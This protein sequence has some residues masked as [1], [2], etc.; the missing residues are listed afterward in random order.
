MANDSR[1]VAVG[2]PRPNGAVCHAPIGTALPTDETTPLDPAFIDLGYVHADGLERAIT[3][4]FEDLKAWG[5]DTVK[6]PQTEVGVSFTFT[7][8]ESSNGDV[9]NAIFGAENVTITPASA[10][11]G[12]KIAVAFT[13][14][15]LGEGAWN[16]DLKDGDNLRRITVPR[17][18]NTTE[19]FTQTFSDVELIGYPVTLTAFKDEVG[20]YFYEYSDNG[21]KTA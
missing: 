16:F 14:E 1:N 13:G 2:K 17:A 18:I 3:R 8:I 15:P 4:A 19:D 21:V 12:T 5:G 7:L 10:S 20:S 11:A 9:A 6:R